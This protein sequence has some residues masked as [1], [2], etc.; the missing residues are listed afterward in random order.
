MKIKL[1][2]PAIYFDVSLQ[3]YFHHFAEEQVALLHFA[4]S[5]N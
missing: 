1:H 4:Q 5:V 3:A 2:V